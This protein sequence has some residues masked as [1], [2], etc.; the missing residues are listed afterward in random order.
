MSR[1]LILIAISMF[2][3]GIGEGL[4][5]YFQPIY[6]QQLGADPL[7]I[8]T[9]LGGFGLMMTISHIPAG[10]LADRLGR[11]PV[12]QSAW[13]MGVV[14]TWIMALT[15]SLPIFV[16]GLLLYGVTMFV[17]SPLY[18]Y[19]TA[20]RGD[21][22]V[23][24]ALTL[25][26]AAFNLGVVIG[27]TLGGY[28]GETLGLRQT[29][30]IASWIFVVSTAIIFLI[31]P[32]PVNKIALQGQGNGRLLNQ[33]SGLYL[34]IVF[35]AMFATY[36][37]QPLSPNFLQN[38][39]SLSLVQIGQLYS[40]SSIGVVVLNLGLGQL[41][42]RIGFMLGQGAVG[43]FTV[44]LWQGTG[45]PWY[46]VGYFLLGG[47]KTARSLATAQMRDLIH[48]ARMGLSYGVTETVSSTAMIL[49]PILA[50]YLYERNPVWMYVAGAGLVL[51]SILVNALFS[52]ISRS[53]EVP[54]AH[55]NAPGEP[56]LIPGSYEPGVKYDQASDGD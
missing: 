18:S 4:F 30:F 2:S 11:R 12:M 47:Y 51:A 24:R 14:A 45:L 7:R 27:P 50:G 40:V 37:P 48:E 56:I 52:P 26:S 5:L 33:R 19:V 22:S 28:I 53:V 46:M 10:Y 15:N 39:R 36:L 44:L 38:Q 31:R 41:P 13:V 8:G 16:T 20:A 29:Y 3:W 21:L 23:G 35:L 32:Q 25:I 9:I 17:L 43:L 34:G 42:A 54:A 1:D 55:P 49:A 6:L